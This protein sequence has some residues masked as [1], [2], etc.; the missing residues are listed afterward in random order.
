MKA[1]DLCCSNP[2]SNGQYCDRCAAHVVS[3]DTCAMCGDA[4][5]SGDGLCDDCAREEP[6]SCGRCERL[7]HMCEC[8]RVC[9]LCDLEECN[10]EPPF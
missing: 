7:F 6:D 1:C 8:I 5:D 9:S 4:V 3:M 2:A 10:C